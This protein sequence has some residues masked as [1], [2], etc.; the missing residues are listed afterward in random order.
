MLNQNRA[1]DGALR[2]AAVQLCRDLGHS[3]LT[4]WPP[5][6]PEQESRGQKEGPS[7]VVDRQ[8]IQVTTASPPNSPAAADVNP[9]LST[10][11]ILPATSC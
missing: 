2:I 6:L 9:E 3:A 11:H 10:S 5:G 8:L 4:V 7:A 1:F